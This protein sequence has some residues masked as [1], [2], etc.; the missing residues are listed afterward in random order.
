ML[1]L[2]LGAGVATEWKDPIFGHSAGQFMFD[3]FC[4]VVVVAIGF[5]ILRRLGIL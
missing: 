4:F 5:W 2:L 1:S 3:V